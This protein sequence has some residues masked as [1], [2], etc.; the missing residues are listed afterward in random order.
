[1]TMTLEEIQT[2]AE[3]KKF[4]IMEWLAPETVDGRVES[5]AMV[6]LKR[7]GGFLVCL[8]VGFLPEEVL[9]EG[10]VSGSV[11]T[12]G[13]S[14]MISAAGVLYEDGKED[15]IGVPIDAVLVD[16]D[17]SAL[18]LFRE[19]ELQE[20]IAMS[21]SEEDVNA[22]PSPNAVLEI[23]CQWLES[24]EVKPVPGEAWYT[25]EPT[26]ESAVESVGRRPK[27][28]AKAKASQPGASTTE[29]PKRVTTASLAAAVQ[30]VVAT[31]PTITEQMRVMLEKQKAMEERMNQQSSVSAALSQ[32]L[33]GRQEALVRERSL[34]SGLASPPRMRSHALLQTPVP[35]PP[36]EVLELEK[37]R[38]ELGPGSDLAQAMLAQSAALTSPVAQITSNHQD[39]LQDLQPG[40]Q[41]GVRGAQGRAR[42]QQELASQKG[43][44][45][46]SVVLSM[47]RRMAPTSVA[48]QPYGVLL[49]NGI[50]GVRYLERFG[51]YGRQ[52][53]LGILM[54]QVMTAIDFLMAG[55]VEAAKDTVALM[56]V[57][58]EQACLDGGRFELAQCLTLQEDI[59]ASIFTSRQT[60][61]L[62]RSRAFAPLADQ[63]WITVA[64]AFLKEMDVIVSKR[65]ELTSTSAASASGDAASTPGG[66]QGKGG[67]KKKKNKKEGEGEEAA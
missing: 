51:G 52:K 29:R 32:P 65:G 13:P 55:N 42:L 59:P 61:Q 27:Q 44:F 14:K 41:A 10:N 66:G 39:P 62:S 1:M 35:K 20:D 23:A 16:L 8:P 6:V 63:R 4:Y 33:G 37:E 45:F 30:D 18:P 12:V 11:E 36:A 34:V 40:A 49:A 50:S 7:P 64:L 31:L 56:A 48:D 17:V 43:L 60:S 57:M 3:G 15:P 9:E 54:F 47:A 25:P 2:F 38:Q 21:F 24:G 26:G 53:D 5:Y 58:L 28:R 19:V 46:H 67:P 22:Y